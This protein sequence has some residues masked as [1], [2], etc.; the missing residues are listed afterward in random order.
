MIFFRIA[1]VP[2]ITRKSAA[3]VEQRWLGCGRKRPSR[4]GGGG[5]VARSS[6]TETGLWWRVVRIGGQSDSA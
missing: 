1:T 6:E 5:G 4:D 3:S 2:F